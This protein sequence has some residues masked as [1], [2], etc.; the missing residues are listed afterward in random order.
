MSWDAVGLFIFL[1][2]CF[3]LLFHLRYVTILTLVRVRTEQKGLYTALITN[4]DDVKEVTFAL[5]VQGKDF[6]PLKGS[7]L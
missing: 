4:E 2:F 6:V 7:L 3:P 5:E 1:S